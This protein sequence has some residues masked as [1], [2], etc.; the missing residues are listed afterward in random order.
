LRRAF[1]DEASNNQGCVK[2]N[3]KDGVHVQVHVEVAVKA[4]GG[5]PI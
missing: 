3:V 1:G 2:V 5:S 4:I